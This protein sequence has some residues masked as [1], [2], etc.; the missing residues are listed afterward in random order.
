MPRPSLR[1][2][3]VVFWLIMTGWLVKDEVLPRFGFGELDYRAVLQ[4]RARKKLTRWHLE[5]DG[6]DVGWATTEVDPQTDGSF[7]ILTELYL[8]ISNFMRDP[9]DAPLNDEAS[10]RVDMTS[11]IFVDPLGR[12][13]TLDVGLTVTPPGTGT[14]ASVNFDGN[15]RGE[16]LEIKT[17]GLGAPFEDM[18]L[19]I[20][21]ESFFADKMVPLD[22]IPDLRVGKKWTTR[23]INPFV[24]MSGPFG[25]LF[26]GQSV[27]IIQNEVTG[28]ESINME[29]RMWRCHVIEHRREETF[30]TT[31]VRVSDGRVLRREIEFIGM[32]MTF[33]LDFTKEDRE[34]PE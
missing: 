9:A 13:E 33:S 22:Q 32:S 21:A 7:G 18:R 5:R 19:P 15:V 24:A 28:I 11:D 10:T 16:Y 23:T 12:L 6:R 25:M 17:Q 4:E 14:P 31:W 2:T 1:I 8:N 3:I 27:E 34:V 29:D 30:S 20:N 26:R